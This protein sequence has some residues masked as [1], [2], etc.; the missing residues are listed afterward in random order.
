MT[1][2]AAHVEDSHGSR[3]NRL[4]RRALAGLLS[5]A[6]LASIA[7]VEGATPA[8]EDT[9]PSH[10]WRAAAAWLVDQQRPDGGFPGPSGESDP[11]TTI[12]AV[13]A[14]YA[15]GSRC[16][17]GPARDYLHRHGP[18]Y[19]A[20][21]PGQSARLA[22]A[23]IAWVEDPQAFGGT[24]PTMVLSDPQCPEYEHSGGIDLMTPILDA[25][26][27]PEPGTNPG[28][29]GRDL[30]DHA[31]A[32]LALSA[33][34]FTD[35]PA[36]PLDPFRRT[37]PANGGWARDGSLEESATDSRTT[38]LVIQALTEWEWPRDWLLRRGLAFLRSLQMGDGS[39][40][41]DQHAFP[42]AD[43]KSTAMVFQALL[44]ARRRTI[45]P[46]WGDVPQA[47]VRFQLPSG[48]FRFQIGDDQ[49]DLPASLQAIV[50]LSKRYLPVRYFC[51]D[52]Y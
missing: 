18:R 39:H 6:S 2:T 17:L 52:L 13:M 50:A 14:M 10:S 32:L 45:P 5:L 16:S 43:A 36:V 29:I 24:G 27:A 37:Q 22:L 47:L 28:L 51:S 15:L 38:A 34:P 20:G 7:S 42:V 41:F 3:Q 30:H 8:P 31:Y 46:R 9:G 12:D 21:G 25:L 49:P 40:V 48:G 4:N 26:V 44:A 11:E 33:N 19:A 1:D 35:F 23:A